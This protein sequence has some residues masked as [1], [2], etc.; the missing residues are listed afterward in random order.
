MKSLGPT[1]SLPGE[2]ITA[3]PLGRYPGFDGSLITNLSSQ[4]DIIALQQDVLESY[5]SNAILGN[6]AAGQIANGGYDAFNSDTLSSNSI[7]GTYDATNKVYSNAG[8]GIP[9]GN[10]AGVGN[11]AVNIS[12]QH[13]SF[14]MNFT[15]ASGAGGVITLARFNITQVNNIGPSGY[16]AEIW[17]NV[18]SRPGV[19]VG[20]SSDVYPTDTTPGIKTF[21]WSTNAP[22]LSASTTY[23]VV[24]K[25]PS[26][27]ADFD[28][29]TVSNTSAYK[30]G[31]STTYNGIT[32]ISDNTSFDMKFDVMLGTAPL[33]MTLITNPFNQTLIGIPSVIKTL[34][35]WKDQSGSAV[36]NTDLICS[37]TRNG[38]T[39]TTGTLID[40]GAMLN[41]YKLLWASVNVAGQSS[42]SIT[43]VK[44]VTTAKI[45][46]IKAI[47][48]MTK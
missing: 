29:S 7:N 16:V 25:V 3:D 19:K 4:A 13:A 5:L 24:F 27:S 28:I 23:W 20:G 37:A 1:A 14:G 30:N 18:S 42:G 26:N 11:A 9:Y 38:S 36:I 35:S 41:G 34:I 6:W 48:M 2:I 47:S 39:Y 22:I 33:A 15:T 17:T 32:S 21:T 10:G 44:L 43:R 31:V 12:G 46:W 8:A 40:T 45:Q